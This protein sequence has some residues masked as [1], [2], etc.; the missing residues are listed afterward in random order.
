MRRIKGEITK[1][2]ASY[3]QRLLIV[4]VNKKQQYA[5]ANRAEAHWHNDWLSKISVNYLISAEAISKAIMSDL[6]QC[7]VAIIR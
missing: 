1:D 4:V 5:I 7:R 6:V 2:I 3:P